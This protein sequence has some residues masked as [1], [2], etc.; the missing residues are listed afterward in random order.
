[1][2]DGERECRIEA[3]RDADRWRREAADEAECEEIVLSVDCA[4][5]HC[6]DCDDDARTC[7]CVC[8]A[9]PW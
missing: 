2:T 7:D 3:A 4:F 9:L 8:H 1:M 6:E 5:G